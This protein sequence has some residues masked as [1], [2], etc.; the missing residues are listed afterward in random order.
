A[1]RKLD[2]ITRGLFIK[3]NYSFDGYF[4]NY[5]TRTKNER[6]AMYTGTGDLKDPANYI[7]AGADQPLSAPSSSYA[8]SR[9]VWT[10]VSLNYD[11]VFGDHAVTGL[12]LANRTQEVTRG[13]IPFVSQGL[14]S[15]FTYAYQSKYYAELNV[16]YNGTD[17]FAKGKRYGLFPA[18]SAGWVVS[19]EK[20]LQNSPV[21]DFLKL[22]ASY[23]IT[24]N[25]QLP[26]R[27]WLFVSDYQGGSAGYGYGD[28]LTNISGVAEGPAAN[29]AVTWETSHKA[30]A[31]IELKMWQNLFGLTL[32]V[33][34]EKRSDILI[35]RGSVPSMIGVADANLP[36]ANMGEIV[37]KGFEVE[38][39][40]HNRIGQ[41]SYFLSANGSFVRNKIRFM[42]EVSWP[43]DYERRTGHPVNQMFG[44]TALGF[45]QDQADIDKSPAQFG[46]VIPGDL[47]YK[48]LNHDNVI[49]ANDI[50]PIGRSNVPEILYGISGGVNWKN[51][52]LSF[53]F[54]G[55]AN[56]NVVFDHEGAWEFYNGAKVMVQ[57]LGRWTPATASTATYP[58][59]HYGQNNNNH[60]TSTFWMKDASYLRLKNIELGYTFKQVRLSKTTRVSGIRIF[61]SGE[62]LLTWDH[63]GNHNFDPEAASGKGFFYPQLKIFNVGFS[64]EF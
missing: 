22:R 23:G 27:R 59:L 15:R 17:N 1:T 30:N 28:P 46:K 18:V 9:D 5:F 41:V 39:S 38:L 64:T 14:V 36:P 7:Y 57:H 6:T 21:I 4:M 51:F 32:D 45:F 34:R 53:L 56:Y 40:H 37:N 50:G 20:F 26:G 48:D 47:K 13:M 54:Q 11:R 42:D 52:D 63:L 8:Q 60:R 12:L 35:T 33:F 29:P 2:F 58:V 3:G 31:G 19:Q 55:A 49:D 62:N 25:D 10:D 44:L 61:A 16:G 43:Y 24:G